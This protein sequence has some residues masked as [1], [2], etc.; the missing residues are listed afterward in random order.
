MREFISVTGCLRLPMLLLLLCVLPDLRMVLMVRGAPVVVVCEQR[1]H[2]GQTSKCAYTGVTSA[3]AEIRFINDEEDDETVKATPVEVVENGVGVV[4]VEV[5]LLAQEYVLGMYDGKAKTYKSKT[6]VTVVSDEGGESLDDVASTRS[7]VRVETDKPLYAPGQKIKIRTLVADIENTA[8]IKQKDGATVASVEVKDALERT[9]FKKADCAVDVFGVA[10][11]EVAIAKEQPPFGWWTVKAEVEIDDDGS[12]VVGETGFNVEEYVLPSFDVT[13]DASSMPLYVLAS[14]SA[15]EFSGKVESAYTY[16]KAVEGK[17]KVIIKRPSTSNYYYGGA[18]G[19]DVGGGDFVAV[20]EPA[21]K[22]PD[23]WD[24]SG[25][26]SSSGS[27]GYPNE[28]SDILYE[29]SWMT[30]YEGSATFVASISKSM[31][32]QQWSR[33]LEAYTMVEEAATREI[34]NS[35]VLIVPIVREAFT[36]QTSMIYQS[37]ALKPGL[38]MKHTIQLASDIPGAFSD[39]EDLG[40]LDFTLNIN[41]MNSYSYS[42]DSNAQTISTRV[43]SSGALDI[44]FDAPANDLSCCAS[45]EDET[46]YFYGSSQKCCLQGANVQLVKNAAS[47]DVVKKI[48]ASASDDMSTTE[49]D[50]LVPYLSVYFARDTSSAKASVE[51]VVIN[52]SCESAEA[53]QFT[54]ASSRSDVAFAYAVVDAEGLGRGVLEAGTTTL[55]STE[56]EKTVTM[57]YGNIASTLSAA[58]SIAVW[59]LSGSVYSETYLAGTTSD[60]FLVPGTSVSV[61]SEH[62]I[63]FPYDI[64]MN[65]NVSE[66]NVVA[67][68]TD[69]TFTIIGASDGARS[70]ILAIDEAVVI[71]SGGNTSA[72]E[73]TTV[74]SSVYDAKTNTLDASSNTRPCDATYNDND[75]KLDRVTIISTAEIASYCD[76]SSSSNGGFEVGMPEIAFGVDMAMDDVAAG[77]ESTTNKAATDVDSASS[78]P[79]VRT[80]FPETW[81]WES[82]DSGSFESTAPDSITTWSITAFTS[83]PT[84]GISILKSASK[85]TVF[86]EF[87]ISPKVPYSISRGETVE[88]VLAVFNYLKDQDMSVLV[89][90]ED[91]TSGEAVQIGDSKTINVSKNS[92]DSIFFETSP[93]V[94]GSIKL[95]FSAIGTT[96]TST[97]SESKEYTDAVEKSIVVNPEGVFKTTTVS[98][99]FRRSAEDASETFTLNALPNG[100]SANAIADTYSSFITVVGDI[101]GPSI[102]NI[103]KFVQIP[104]GCGEQNLLLLAPNVYIAEYLNSANKLTSA[105]KTELSNNVIMGYSRELTYFHPSG[106]VSAFGPQSDKSA[107]LWLTAFCSKV[108]ASAKRSSE[109]KILDGVS[110]DATVLK[111]AVDF[112]ISTQGTNGA[113]SEPGVVL[114]SEMQSQSGDKFVLSSYAALSLIE[115]VASIDNPSTKTSA[116]NSIS[117]ALEYVTSSLDSVKSAAIAKEPSAVYS[118]IV[119]TYAFASACASLSTHCDLAN[120]WIT[121]VLELIGT[122]EV[123]GATSYGG[124][125]ASNSLKIESTAYVVLIYAKMSDS[126]NNFCYSALKF[127]LQ[128]RNEFGGYGS[129]QDTVVALEALSTYAK[130]TREASSSGLLV[131]SFPNEVGAPSFTVDESSFDTFNTAQIA[132]RGTE[133]FTN[134]SVSGDVSGSGVA[135]VSY[136]VRWYETVD[137][138]EDTSDGLFTIDVTTRV[139]TTK[140][141]STN[142]KK[143]RRLLTP[144]YSPTSTSS[145]EDA[146]MLQMKVCVKKTEITNGADG[147]A[148][149]RVPMFSGFQPVESSIANLDPERKYIKRV[150]VDPITSTLSLYIENFPLN[151]NDK[152]CATFD[153]RRVA[154]VKNAQDVP[155]AQI[156]MYYQQDKYRNAVMKSTDLEVGRFPEDDGGGGVKV[157]PDSAFGFRVTFIL[158]SVIALALFAMD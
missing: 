79:T 66:T 130:L 103:N 31:L 98:K 140:I 95:R 11:A 147:M 139:V 8:L 28:V 37:P 117:S 81:L 141:S 5:P 45:Y 75:I 145:V 40:T 157:E 144:N 42:G 102:Q 26:S 136:T 153:A 82:S 88:I 50:A 135:V 69:I 137:L 30:L 67:T 148:L 12:K 143:R 94:L 122:S 111:G 44:E 90:A 52:A 46:N 97:D 72:L 27:S 86:R 68:G 22:P 109:S 16:G 34:R 85:M 149:L 127:L 9:I 101:M 55:S 110:I 150:E 129:T 61:E 23:E 80:L 134:P 116:Q 64:T 49:L 10:T 121:G 59:S 107:S 56:T 131:L 29:S 108:F 3:G 62:E 113:F 138:T 91:V 60:V 17:A 115:T 126:G 105:L 156:S 19:G 151:S 35:T 4:E 92:A 119:S 123:D 74:L 2:A 132:Q 158:A 112:I 1:F 100:L 39:T 6:K 58:V 63:A 106:G 93:T 76:P 15:N 78:S 71:Q 51:V 84:Q 152:L 24:S 33:N 65:T 146:E 20:E 77:Q 83:H 21:F 128:N 99:V 133:T 154:E 125:G 70:Y 7:L 14:K 53:C 114:H 13:F 54:L 48:L 89:S 41:K 73:A 104:M 43:S 47:R 118:V 87:F 96:T 57:T 18:V 142:R 155:G 120:S 32:D 124:V 25:S 36:Q 38:P